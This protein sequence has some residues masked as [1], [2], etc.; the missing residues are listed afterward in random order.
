MIRK[1]LAKHFVIA[2]HDRNHVLPRQPLHDDLPMLHRRLI[3]LQDPFQ[4]L[5]VQIE[6]H[7]VKSLISSEPSCEFRGPIGDLSGQERVGF[8]P[9]IFLVEVAEVFF[10]GDVVHPGEEEGVVVVFG[11]GYVVEE[12][13]G[14]GELF[15]GTRPSSPSAATDVDMIPVLGQFLQGHARSRRRNAHVHELLII[16]DVDGRCLGFFVNAIGK[17]NVCP[18]NDGFLLILLS[19]L[20]L[21]GFQFGFGRQNHP[22]PPRNEIIVH[23]PHRFHRI[24]VLPTRQQFLLD[25]PLEIGLTEIP[26]VMQI[27]REIRPPPNHR[28]NQLLPRRDPDGL[29]VH[30]PQRVPLVPRS[31]IRTD[32]R[33]FHRRR[34]DFRRRLFF[35]IPFQLFRPLVQTM[36]MIFLRIRHG[37]HVGNDVGILK[38]RA[39]LKDGRHFLGMVDAR[40][41]TRESLAGVAF[42]DGPAAAA[43]AV[44]IFGI[45][46]L[47]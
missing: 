28:G 36:Q 34:R 37:D 20:F 44:G 18:W 23:F 12:E 16:V 6:V 21:L 46:V 13:A 32:A 2:L 35:L 39:E 22:L 3:R 5:P 4:R 45:F 25:I 24:F 30:Q 38:D 41:G 26:D 8:G 42:F 19:L 31:V 33:Q 14:H 40:R 11:G 17:F 1:I 7:F 10:D 15:N 47:V 29:P 43:A 9:L 27:P